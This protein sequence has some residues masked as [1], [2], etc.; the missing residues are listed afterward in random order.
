MEE[1]RIKTSDVERLNHLPNAFR[2][3]RTGM[4]KGVS[5]PAADNFKFEISVCLLNAK[6]CKQVLQGGLYKINSAGQ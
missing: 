2:N 5:G 1:S 6:K 4:Q 3:T